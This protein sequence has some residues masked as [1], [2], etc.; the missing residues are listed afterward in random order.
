MIQAGR[1][2]HLQD[3]R[4]EVGGVGKPAP[5][6]VREAEFLL[7]LKRVE[8]LGEKIFSSRAK[9]PRSS[10]YAGR[11]GEGPLLSFEFGLAIVV[12]GAYRV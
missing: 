4:C 10:D 7:G 3:G 5:L 9:H 12:A 8:E 6:I 1:F 2:E 11:E